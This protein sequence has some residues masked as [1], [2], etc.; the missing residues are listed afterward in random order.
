MAAEKVDAVKES[1]NAMA[2][3]TIRTNQALA[4]GF[5]RSFWAT[6]HAPARMAADL[7]N[8]VLG[9]LNKGIAP[10]HR[11]ATANAKRLAR[12]KSR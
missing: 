12:T 6:G 9:I 11:K 7:Q 5:F 4:A 3:Q 8:A 10:A 2:L 1:W